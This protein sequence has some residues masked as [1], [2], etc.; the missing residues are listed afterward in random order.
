[1][2]KRATI[3]DLARAAGL[4]VATVDRVLKG[5][6]ALRE[7]TAQRVA[8]AAEAIGFH[9]AGLLKQ[10]A[11]EAPVRTFGFLL[12]K[13]DNPCYQ[14]LGSELVAAV[15][16]APAV[17]G[18][19][20]VY[21]TDALLPC[22][23]AK[24][25]R[26]VRRSADALAVVAVDHPHVNEAIA[27]VSGRG[28][29]IFTR[30][31]DVTA[32]ARAGYIGV[33]SRKRGRTAGWAIA[34]LAERPGPVGVMVGTHRYLSQELAEMSFRS[35]LRETA[36]EFTVLETGVDLENDR[37]AYEATLHLLARRDDLRGIYL[38]GGG[39]QGMID[40]LRDEAAG[41]GLVVVCNELLPGTRAAL[42]DGIVDLVLSTPLAALAARTVEAMA[43]ASAG[44]APD[45]ILQVQLPAELYV[46]ENLD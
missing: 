28:V 18:K 1:M 46:S 20:L 42:L 43:R 16:A 6:A 17:R 24:R 8:E 9:A 22:A 40:A 32:P 44:G 25:I 36:P 5:R 4:S 34:R 35:Y 27:E 26:E 31:S 15:R 38:A 21:F 37:I 39:M 41:R 2:P 13:R 19:A 14:A 7:A 12:Q 45:G 10:R 11:A 29:P 30:L 23:M 3:A 33:D